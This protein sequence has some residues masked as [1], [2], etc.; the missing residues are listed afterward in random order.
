LSEP[1]TSDAAAAPPT[2]FVSYASE[3]RE[4]A[5]L[6]QEALPGYGLEVWF[7]ESELGG[8]EA[9]DQKIRRQIRECDDFMPLVSA[10]TER[11]LEGY[12]R[13]EWRIAVERTLDMADDH[14][15]LLPIVIDDTDQSSAR[16]P[17]KF[18]TVQWLR[19]PGGRPTRALESL[20]RRLAAGGVLDLKGDPK[21]STQ[22]I[23]ARLASRPLATP[24]FPVQEPGQP[25]RFW[26][27]VAGWAGRSLW[28][29]FKRLPKWIRIIAVV[30]LCIALV[31]RCNSSKHEHAADDLTPAKL[32][33]LKAITQ[34]YQGNSN[35][36]D[37]AKLGA[38][39]ASE[40]DLDD[41]EPTEG[42]PLLAIAFTAPATDAASTKLAN[43]AFALTYGMLAIA[44]HGQVA[45]TKEP[46]A[47]QNLAAAIER[48]KANH[49]Q[50]VLSG[51]IEAAAGA[52]VLTVK[53]AKV[54]DGSVLWSKTY[55]ATGADPVSIAADIEKHIPALATG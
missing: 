39:I 31:S 12:F 29:S 48:G 7:D 9:W 34:G 46:L 53:L 40:F 25:V 44:H 1:T 38:S 43:A 42:V 23:K 16:V 26:V 24:E 37:L 55:P 15:F 50:Y 2:V 28:V 3:D 19:V 32:E 14:L 8:G 17:E 10:Q 6:I 49:S 27:E 30:W 35:A 45:L 36:T 21:A 18:F 11:R 13:R 52:P 22:T 51:S 33:K 20:C 47:S 5:R 54:A 41:D 4:A